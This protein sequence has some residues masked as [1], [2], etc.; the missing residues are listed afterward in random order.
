MKPRYAMHAVNLRQGELRVIHLHACARRQP[1][2][3][4]L[5]VHDIILYLQ[6]HRL[7][8]IP[9]PIANCLSR[10]V[11]AQ[12]DRAECKCNLQGENAKGSQ[13]KQ[14][15]IV[16]STDLKHNCHVVMCISTTLSGEHYSQVC[17][18]LLWRIA[19]STGSR[20]V[21]VQIWNKLH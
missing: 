8:L 18:Y 11:S 1:K 12:A 17:L 2:R 7:Y 5:N 13:C 16:C 21:H 20:P 6:E 10:M 3:G 14:I 19:Y 9:R 4:R 15:L